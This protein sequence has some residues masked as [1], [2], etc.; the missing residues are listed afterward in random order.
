MLQ[1]RLDRCPLIPRLRRCAS[2]RA[3]W[4]WPFR[5]SMVAY[6]E[7]G[8]LSEDEG[9]TF[10]LILLDYILSFGLVDCGF[11]LLYLHCGRHPSYTHQLA[12]YR[13]SLTCIS[14]HI[15]VV[16]AAL[17]L[18]CASL[19]RSTSPALLTKLVSRRGLFSRHIEYIEGVRE[20]EHNGY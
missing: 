3:C 19:G 18:R 10:E 4:I 7:T 11:L 14:Y 1:L 13:P 20:I 8:F 9:L 2:Q 6:L 17:T 15:L 12:A 5:V 16:L